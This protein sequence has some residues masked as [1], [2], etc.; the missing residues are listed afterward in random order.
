MADIPPEAR[1]RARRTS[2][3]DTDNASQNTE[4]VAKYMNTRGRGGKRR[5]S[6]IGTEDMAKAVAAQDR[7]RRT[8]IAETSAGA[9]GEIKLTAY[10]AGRGQGGA[11][12]ESAVG[13]DDLAALAVASQAHDDSNSK[14]KKGVL[15]KM[16]AIM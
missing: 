14:G 3:V 11:R 7:A 6:A 5:S 10:M 4:D 16:C 2:V 9:E 15:S 13:T 8:S 12:R 1:S